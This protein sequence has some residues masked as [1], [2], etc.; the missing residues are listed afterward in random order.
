MKLKLWSC[1]L[2]VTFLTVIWAVATISFLMTLPLASSG[3]S[4]IFWILFC[5]IF[6][7]F[8]NLP[9]ISTAVWPRFDIWRWVISRVL[10][11]AVC[12]ID[13]AHLANSSPVLLLLP[14][15][16]NFWYC[17]IPVALDIYDWFADADRSHPTFGGSSL[18]S[19]AAMAV[20][21]NAKRLLLLLLV[22]Y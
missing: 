4:W 18:P 3:T 5:W 14:C 6:G 8:V 9:E 16:F 12:G 7:F 20:W 22:N 15:V 19:A 2:A 10:Y 17:T 21:Y 13:T 1:S 11:F